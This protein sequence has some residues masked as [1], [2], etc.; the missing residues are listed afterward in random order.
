MKKIIAASI[1]AMQLSPTFA[2]GQEAEQSI[3]DLDFLIGAWRGEATLSYPREKNRDARLETVAAE[4]GY[5]LKNT[6]I[7]CD[8]VWTRDGGISR[9]FRLHFNYNNLDHAYQ[10]LFVYDSWP[11]HVSYLVNYDTK[12][13]AY[14]GLSDFEDEEGVS[15]QERILWRVSEDGNEIHSEEYIHLEAEPADY[16][17]KN[18]EFVWRKVQ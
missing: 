18:F 10:T 5:I 14:I 2:F 8:T 3:K 7:Q 12:A 6:Y 13:D 16:W 17:P 11:R 15:G 1:L 9:T 4:C